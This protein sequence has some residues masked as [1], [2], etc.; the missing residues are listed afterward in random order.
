[1]RSCFA[2]HGRRGDLIKL[3]FGGTALRVKSMRL[4]LMNTHCKTAKRL[5]GPCEI[6]NYSSFMRKMAAKNY[7]ETLILDLP[8]R[9]S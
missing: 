5:K 6:L 3:F 1:M 9:W 4:G 8:G 2:F 7:R